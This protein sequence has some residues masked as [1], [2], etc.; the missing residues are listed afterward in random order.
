[1]ADDNGAD[2]ETDGDNRTSCKNTGDGQA[3]IRAGDREAAGGPAEEALSYSRIFWFWI[4]LA[5]MWFM[6]AVEQP[7]IAAFVAR[8]P[9]PEVNLAAQGVVFAIAMIIE[10]PIIMLLAAGTALSRGAVSYR[11][12]L[13]FSHLLIGGLTLLHFLIAVTPLYDLILVRVIGVPDPVVELGRS[14]FLVVTPWSAAVG[15]RRLWQGVLIRHDRTGVVPVTIAIRLV[16]TAALLVTGYS[17]GRF[18]GVFVGAASLAGGVTSAAVAAYLFARPVIRTRLSQL[19]QE[20]NPVSR[21]ELVRF[22]VPLALTSLILMAARPA[23]TVAISRLPQ[24]I[25]SLAVWPVVLSVSFL[26]RSIAMS[27]QET[28]IALLRGRRSLMMLQRFARM[29]GLILL[30][31]FGVFALTPLAEIWFRRVVG[32]SASLTR[33]AR[34]PMAVLALLPGV[35]SLISWQRGILVRARRTPGITRSVLVNLFVLALILVVLGYTAPINGV[36][37]AA[38]AYIGSVTAEWV[39]LRVAAA[40][41]HAVVLSSQV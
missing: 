13:R 24:P 7:L 37:I 33:I 5:V 2:L 35:S 39:Y 3:A 32:L 16:V 18:P 25:D 36:L 21:V 26:G 20:T 15:Y 10:S 31:L 27:Y 34:I 1:M 41:A 22:Y 38:V 23:L 6:M 19:D 12:L 14:A 29:L 4:P 28:G 17:V 8:M 30:V 9:D 11:R 40:R